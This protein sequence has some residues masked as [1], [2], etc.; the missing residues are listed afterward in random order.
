MKTLLWAMYA[1]GYYSTHVRFEHSV[2]P[3]DFMM[4]LPPAVDALRG[5]FIEWLKAEKKLAAW[6]A[7]RAKDW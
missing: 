1:G 7:L 2:E 5:C 3:A 6:P 4:T